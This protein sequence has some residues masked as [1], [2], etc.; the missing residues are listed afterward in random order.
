MQTMEPG[1]GTDTPGEKRPW[2]K[3]YGPFLTMGIQL[4]LTVVVCFFLGRWLDGM[5]GTA[6][7]L[8]IAGLALG[9]V[10]GMLSFFRAAAAAGKEEDQRAAERR[11]H[12]EG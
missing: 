11:E 1:S 9:I 6:P 3:L 2:G 10:G 7:W 4:A 12:H 5:L 8:M